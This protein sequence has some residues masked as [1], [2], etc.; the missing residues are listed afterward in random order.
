MRP[1]RAYVPELRAEV[2]IEGPEGAH[3]VRVLRARPGDRLTLFDGQG[4]EALA[5]VVAIAGER[6]RVRVLDLQETDR[7]PDIPVTLYLAL[8][9]GEKL[10]DVVRMGTEL[11]VSRFVLV[12]S[13]RSVAKAIGKGKLDRAMR[14]AVEAAKQSG[15]TRL[16]TIEGPL[17][18]KALPRV[19]QGLVA[20]PHASA[21][22]GDVL[23]PSRPVSLLVGPEGG[24]SEEE[25][26]LAEA[27]GFTPVTLGRRILRAETAAC[28]LVAL[29]TAA[30]GQ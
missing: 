13:Q 11:G 15:R 17:P 14:V 26:R 30:R 27:R 18:L 29:V 25:L 23:D 22:V 6:V 2:W 4:R 28:T 12:V 3:L 1:H 7:E 5:E 24:L 8:L 19:G 21:R 16:P 9:K 20:E 10:F